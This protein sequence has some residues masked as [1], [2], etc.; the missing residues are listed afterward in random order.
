LQI[1]F[2]GAAVAICA[3][4]V[5]AAGLWHYI[6]TRPLIVELLFVPALLGAALVLSVGH[7]LWPR[8]FF[9]TFG[10]GA[11]VVVS[12]VLTLERAAVRWLRLT[13]QR[14]ARLSSLALAFIIL[15]SA[16]SI[17]FAFG[18]KQD[19]D[20][21]LRF[22]EMQRQPGDVIVSTGL[23]SYPYTQLYRAGIDTAESLPALEAYRNGARRVILLYTLEPV[24][25]SMAPD[26][27]AVIRRDFTVVRQFRG[28]LNGG[29][30]YVC[31]AGD[32]GSRS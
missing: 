14:A 4:I 19:Y 15:A 26:I 23:A 9:F 30:V 6:H 28:T 24:L 11:L 13:P 17:P 25:E 21:A 29:T 5:F 1:N 3:L 12:G 20:G 27:M 31:I 32:H 22:A 2:A 16:A 18:P 8:F 10:F 7:H